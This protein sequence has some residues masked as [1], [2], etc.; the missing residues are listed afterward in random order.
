MKVK[1]VKDFH[2]VHIWAISTTE[3]ALTAHL[4]LTPAT[5]NEEELK[6]KSDLKHQLLHKNIQHVTLE[7]ERDNQHCETTVCKV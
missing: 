4:V 1:G 2:H 5:S 6:I 7:T 3:N